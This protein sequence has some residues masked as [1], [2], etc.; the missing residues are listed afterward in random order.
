MAGLILRRFTALAVLLTVAWAGSAC[1]F[2]TETAS[3]VNFGEYGQQAYAYLQYIDQNLQDRDSD[4]G[5]DTVRAQEWIIRELETAGYADAQIEKQDVPFQTDSGKKRTTQN[6]IA[7]LPGQTE[8]Q[9]IVGAHYDA[10]DEGNGTGDNGSGVALLLET[11]CRLV[12]EQ[13]LPET[14]IFVFFGAEEYDLDGSAAYA[15][16]MTKRE[17]ADTLFMIN[18]DSLICGDFC[19]LYGGVADFENRRVDELDAFRRVYAIGVRLGLNLHVIPWTFDHPAP[20]FREPDYPSPSAGD[21]SD[22][23]AFAERGIQ[24]VYFEASNWEI[25]G[26]DRQYDGDSETA[27]AGKFMHTRRDTLTKLEELF[28]GRALYHLRVFS[29]LLNAVLTDH[30]I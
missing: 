21:W 6:I 26:P 22:H 3:G 30:D 9:I 17:V 7:T 11:A 20:G 25:P 12:R 13:P 16:S 18:L 15:R 29:L 1:A 4:G 2:D 5:K 27:D 14:L 8:Q 10:G 24:Y 23:V 28:P 19:Y